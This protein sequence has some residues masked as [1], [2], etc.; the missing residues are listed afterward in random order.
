MYSPEACSS[1]H[2]RNVLT[3]VTTT[4]ERSL[5]LPSR[6]PTLQV[7][8]SQGNHSSDVCHI[9]EFCLFLN[10]IEMELCS[11]YF[12]L[13]CLHLAQCCWDSCMLSHLT[14][15]PFIN[16]LVS[17]VDLKCRC[18]GYSLAAFIM[19]IRHREIDCYVHCDFFRPSIHV[20]SIAEPDPSAIIGS[21]RHVLPGL[22]LAWG[23]I[24]GALT[25]TSL[26]VCSCFL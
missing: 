5:S 13:R 16:V 17:R 25:K 12:F 9:E 19:V 4:P 22:L 2:C 11:V 26:I 6:D 15:V 7:P 8:L 18:E 1:V 21:S 3:R 24:H 10:F 14:I 23:S 20:T